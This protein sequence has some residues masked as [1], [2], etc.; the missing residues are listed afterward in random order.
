MILER[1]MRLRRSKTRSLQI[2]EE[3]KTRSEEEK[4]GLCLKWPTKRYRLH[5]FCIVL[6]KKSPPIFKKKKNLK[7]LT[8]F[9]LF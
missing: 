1:A 6:I 2:L 7:S 4:S 5:L 8:N 9:T 3:E